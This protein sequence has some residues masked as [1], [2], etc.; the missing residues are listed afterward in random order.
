[1]AITKLIADSITSGAVGITNAQS[2]CLD[3]DQT[4]SGSGYF[5]SNIV[6]NTDSGY[7]GLGSIVSQSS[8]IF[9]FSATGLYLIGYTVVGQPLTLPDTFSLEIETTTDNSSYFSSSEVRVERPSSSND[10]FSMFLQCI[11]NVSNTTNR[12]VRFGYGN[13]NGINS[14]QFFGDSSSR[15]ATK[16]DFI[17]LGDSV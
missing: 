4:E 10:R 16:F 5:D 7:S 6:A 9:S 15:I 2:F 1:M 11:F 3:S 12:K 13:A 8:G 17:R 14:I